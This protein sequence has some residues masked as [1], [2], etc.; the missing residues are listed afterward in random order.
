MNIQRHL[1]FWLI[2]S[3]YVLT[4][5]ILFFYGND[6]WRMVLVPDFNRELGLLESSQHVV[7]I[8]VIILSILG[9]RRSATHIEK[10]IF[11]FAALFGTLLLLEEINY[12]QHYLGAVQGIRKSELGDAWSFHNKGDNSS[13]IKSLSD[14][15]LLL[16]FVILPLLPTRRLPMW[17]SYFQP[18]RL[19]VVTVLCSVLLSKIAHYLSDSNAVSGVTL[20][21][22][23]SEFRE[24]FVYYIGLLYVH[25]LVH[26]RRWRSWFNSAGRSNDAGRLGE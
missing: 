26:H 7:I 16:Y 6:F 14:V 8:A 25:E 12:G 17:L 22:S 24:L 21:S 13:R 20:G 2:P 1:F 19:I 15:I 10:S 23:V 9:Y 3:L 5:I 4:M 11:A 18:P